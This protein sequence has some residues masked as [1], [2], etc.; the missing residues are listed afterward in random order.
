MTNPSPADTRRGRRACPDP[1][2]R[3]IPKAEDKSGRRRRR[4]SV[5]TETV[6]LCSKTQGQGIVKKEGEGREW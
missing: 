5:A 3:L 2:P 4:R 1:D 6:K